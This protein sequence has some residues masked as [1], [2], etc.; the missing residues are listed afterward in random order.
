MGVVKWFEMKI[1]ALN[2]LEPM[3]DLTFRKL[4]TNISDEKRERIKKF[5]KLDDAKMVL[6]ADVL[7]RSVIASELKV[8]SKTIEFN[9]NKYGKPF[10][11]GNSRLHFNVS[12]SRDWIVCVI[13]NESVGIDIEKIRPIGFD[14]FEQFF[15]VEEYNT[16][17][18]KNPEKWQLFFFDLWTLKESY[19][20]AVGKGFSIPLKSVTINFLKKGE[21]TV[22]L[23]NKLTNW[24]IKQYDLDPD[25]KTSV[26]G[27]NKAFPDNVMIKKLKYIC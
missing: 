10:L 22:K 27:T 13:D 21:I 16:L 14:L 9:S 19:I 20:K 5:A 25:Y 7:I 1:F 6:L 12:H 3:D 23:D 17:I 4:L 11:K 24:A 2:N 18:A 8:S 26:C 15:S